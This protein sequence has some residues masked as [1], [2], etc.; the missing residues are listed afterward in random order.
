[1][2]HSPLAALRNCS[3]STAVEFALVLPL[4]IIFLLG[5]I[6]AGRLLYTWNQA[7]KATQMGV[8]FA[9]V[10][11]MVPQG[12]ATHDFT[13][14][15]IS[16]G[17]TVSTAV[18]SHA[19]CVSGTCKNCAGS[20]CGSFGNGLGYNDTNFKKIADWMAR[21]FSRLNNNSGQTDYSKIQIDYDNA[22]LGYVSDPSSPSISPLIT[23]RLRNVTF[24]PIL[25]TV[26][27]ASIA[28]P[29]FKATLTAEDSKG[30]Y[31]N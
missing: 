19:E 3:G 2:K 29:D 30:I 4:L 31:S 24:N 21:Y 16:P 23:V 28:L 13:T 20:A 25:L 10:T 9:A 27:G 12:I 15:G 1:M 6:A 22:G 17:E 7:E 18:F 5:I 11:S 8:R 26:F 14:N